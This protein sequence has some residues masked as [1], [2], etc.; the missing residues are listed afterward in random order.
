MQ[1][2]RNQVTRRPHAR[3]PDQADIRPRHQTNSRVLIA[4][5]GVRLAVLTNLRALANAALI[6][7]AS[8]ISLMI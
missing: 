2:K 8:R 1:S 6:Q 7:P 5:L 4:L 3:L